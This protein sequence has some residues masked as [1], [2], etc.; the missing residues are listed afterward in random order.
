MALYALG[1]LEPTIHP[2]AYVHPD[3]TII[4]DVRIGAFSSVWPQAVMRGDDGHIEVGER[5]S[6]QD[7]SVIH[8]TPFWATTVG[9]DCVI[10][11]QVHLEGCQIANG[12]MIGNHAVVMHRVNVGTGA[13]VA[14]NAVALYDLQVPD[15]AMAM[16]IPAKVR[17][18]AAD[19]A[20]I[21]MAAQTYV[22]RVTRYKEGLRR[23][24]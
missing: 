4:G 1:D 21:E 15:G 18:G 12:A 5:T 7:G 17:E 11:H 8:T 20:M 14:A 3:A 23:L 6:I 13:V 2:D 19:P 16:G 22:D 9:D 24:D 10:G